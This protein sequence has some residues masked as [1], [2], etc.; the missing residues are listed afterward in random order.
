MD[1]IKIFLGAYVNFP[2]AQNINCDNIAKY[3]DKD[4]F[5]VHIMYTTMCPVDKKAYKEAGIV[6]HKLWHRRIVWRWSKLYHMKKAKCDIYYLPKMEEMD[7]AFAKKHKGKGKVFISS[8]E[9]V[10]T[11]TTNNTEEYKNYHTKTMDESFSIS[12]CIKESVK[13]FF[14]AETYVLPL[15]VSD[16]SDTEVC[17]KTNV[18]N[19][20]WVGNIKANKRPMLLV[21][22]AKSFPNVDFLMIGDGDMQ[23]DVEAEI[24][25][26]DIKNL[27]ITGRIPNEKV[28]E[29]MKKN[30]LLLMT[31]E[32]EGLPKVTQ[33]AALHAIPSIYINENYRVDFIKDGVNGYG[34]KD[35][36]EMKEKV[37]Y[38]LD[39]P[40]VF[41]KL[42]KNA[43]DIIQSYTWS[44]LIKDYE[45]YFEEVY[46]KYSKK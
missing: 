13:K 19:V 30:D 33:E 43:F 6:L 42:S 8:I 5:E 38:L 7:I 35:I 25:R 17:K 27:V 23:A 12:N 11:E 22:C 3:L 18:K 2:N 10:V 14:G 26:S 41:Q 29:Y 44:N 28:Y 4:K 15:G 34:V 45:K 32:F 9:G 39:N 37:Q 24:L 20:I 46:T 36:E 1:K 40:E 16:R 31:S 21:D